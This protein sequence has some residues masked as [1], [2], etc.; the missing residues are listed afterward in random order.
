MNEIKIKIKDNN[1]NLIDKNKY[2]F[3][4]NKE[5]LSRHF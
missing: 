3:I 5:R 1:N 2:K 4:P